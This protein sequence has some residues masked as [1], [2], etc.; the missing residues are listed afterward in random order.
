MQLHKRMTEAQAEMIFNWYLKG[1]VSKSE[2]M[3]RLGVKERRFYELLSRYKD[4]KKFW[5]KPERTNKH[6]RIAPLLEH[7]IRQE[8]E[9]EKEIIKNPDIPVTAYNFSAIRDAV[10]SKSNQ[11]VSAQTVRNRAYAW[12]YVTAAKPK[13]KHDRIV[14]TEKSG[15]LLQHDSST[16]LWA[17]LAQEKWTLL[18]TIDDYSRMLL[19]AEFTRKETAW[20]HI[21]A[22]KKVVTTFGTPSAYYVDN[23]SIFRFVRHTDSV[24]QSPKVSPDKVMTQWKRVLSDC[25]ID[26]I[27]ALSPEAKGKIERPYR[28][29]QDRIVRKCAKE[30]VTT[31][32]EAKVILREEVDRYNNRQIHSTTKEI[33]SIRF[34][35]SKR[36]G[37][38]AFRKFELPAPSTSL[39]DIFSIQEK[40]IVDGYQRISFRK[41][42]IKVPNYIPEGA[43]ITVQVCPDS[44]KPEVRLRYKDTVFE[45]IVLHKELP[46]KFMTT[47]RELKK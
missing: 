33:P 34:E 19:Y 4:K 22:V 14:L 31:L 3:Q 32:N 47:S 25:S 29:L 12:E 15:L 16:H 27:Y 20:G 41:R 39:E 46:A 40:R 2:T 38:S 10:V 11:N 30:G 21:N 13:A 1:I 9:K 18:T 24:W 37:N 45:T 5:T 28:W 8:L 42:F 36:E 17:P 44:L 7:L 6:R 43:E 26:V 35:R 23:H